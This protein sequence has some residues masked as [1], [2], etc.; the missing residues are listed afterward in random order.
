MDNSNA[1]NENIIENDMSYER[2]MPFSTEAEQSVLGAMFLD[3]QCIPNVLKH[4][5][6]NDFYSPRNRELFE[7]ILD[8]YNRGLPIDIV[9]LK[10]RLVL[11]GT[12]ETVG[13]IRFIMDVANFVPTTENAEYYAKVVEEK[14]VLRRLIKSLGDITEEC[15][16]GTDELNT[17]IAAAQTKIQDISEGRDTSELEHIGRYVRDSI[18]R[19]DAISKGNEENVIKTGFID[20]DKRTAG[21]HNGNLIFIAARPGIGK[22]SFMLNIA[23]NVAVHEKVPVAIFS[24]EMQGI[25]IANRMLSSS[26]QVSME[27]IKRGDIKDK[28]WDALSR[29]VSVLSDA[30]IY[31]DDTSL[32]DIEEIT[33]KCRKLKHERGLG[34]VCIDYL[35]L[36]KGNRRDGNRQLEISEISRSLK[37]LAKNLDVPIVVLS[38]LNRDLEKR[39]EHKPMLSDLRESGSIEQDADIVM[40]L[41]K[42]SAYNEET[43]N[44]NKVECIFAKHRNGETGTEYLTWLGEYTKFSNW[45]G[46]RE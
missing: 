43:E 12:F 11:R 42:D 31:V 25:E 24:L 21:L 4:I 9:T 34:L 36:M 20:V 28:D 2:A 32:I 35:Q 7:A 10:E 6:A 37:I 29:A 33:R 27:S 5:K 13:G 41:Y 45:S 16:R 39:K 30:P 46:S 17:I 15:Y 40:F 23:H 3:R 38:Q 14:S 1:V 44:P 26:S 19:I 18:D 22:S 8:L